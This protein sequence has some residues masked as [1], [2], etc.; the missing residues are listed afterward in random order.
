[1]LFKPVQGST[2]FFYGMH[3]DNISR[4]SQNAIMAT[5]RKYYFD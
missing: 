2:G 4:N 5:Y 3:F 1:M